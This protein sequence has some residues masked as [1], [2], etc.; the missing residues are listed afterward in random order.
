MRGEDKKERLEEREEK[1]A[2][3]NGLPRFVVFI[4]WDE[5]DWASWIGGGILRG[6]KKR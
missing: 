4:I 6:S 2:F 1:R 5:V 3:K